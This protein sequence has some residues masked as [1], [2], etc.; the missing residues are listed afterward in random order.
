MQINTH[1]L[2][3]YKNKKIM[4]F[5]E[6]KFKFKINCKILFNLYILNQIKN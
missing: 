3:E 6:K 5:E 1:Y 2:N 4:L